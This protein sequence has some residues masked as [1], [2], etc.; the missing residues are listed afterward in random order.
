[1]PITIYFLCCYCTN[2]YIYVSESLRFNNVCKCKCV[3]VLFLTKVLVKSFK[4][5][6]GRRRR[7]RNWFYEAT[8]SVRKHNYE[9]LKEFSLKPLLQLLQL[10][11][12]GVV[13]T[14]SKK[15]CLAVVFP[16]LCNRP[17]TYVRI[18]RC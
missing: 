15:Q 10:W 17:R 14:H 18:Y 4:K 5:N 13:C 6:Y 7:K 12:Y 3:M 9:W 8:F 1:M 16:T 2:S 11:L